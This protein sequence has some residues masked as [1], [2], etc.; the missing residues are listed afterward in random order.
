MPDVIRIVAN[1]QSKENADQ[2]ISQMQDK[3]LISCM[4]IFGQQAL[5]F[6]QQRCQNSII[7]LINKKSDSIDEYKANLFYNSK[8]IQC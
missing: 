1:K 6:T 5:L 4:R 3:V 7:Q 2:I 8:C